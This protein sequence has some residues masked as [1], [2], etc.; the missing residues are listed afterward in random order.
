MYSNHG[1]KINTDKENGFFNNVIA[2][3]TQINHS[4]YNVIFINDPKSAVSISR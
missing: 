3:Y 1:F 2:L 4:E